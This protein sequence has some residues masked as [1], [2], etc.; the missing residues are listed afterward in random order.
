MGPRGVFTVLASKHVLG[1]LLLLVA[2]FSTGCASPVD[3]EE[4]KR[5]GKEAMRN[6]PTAE[7][8]VA[9]LKEFSEKAKAAGCMKE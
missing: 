1:G 2:G 8:K 9:A 7:G 4:L 5:Q 6:A 3:C